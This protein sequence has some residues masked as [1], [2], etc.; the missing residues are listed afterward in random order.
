MKTMTRS[1]TYR[2]VKRLSMFLIAVAL[3]T[4]IVSCDGGAGCGGLAEWYLGTSSSEGGQVIV[5]GGPI[6]ADGTVVTIEAVADECYEFVSW[7]GANVSDPYSAIT[8]ITMDQA[9]NVTANF[10]LLSYDLTIDST[11]GGQVTA[12]GEGTSAYDCGTVVGL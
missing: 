2:Y 10:A 3:I 6:F 4:A 8:S 5:S 1:K 12:P 9:Q 11:D 7:T